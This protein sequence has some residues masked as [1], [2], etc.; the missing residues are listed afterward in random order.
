MDGR[1]GDEVSW[2][3]TRCT[4]PLAD[5]DVCPS[6]P[7]PE[8]CEMCRNLPGMPT[9]IYELMSALKD[10]SENDLKAVFGLT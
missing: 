2:Q 8:V 4:R 1:N 7:V 9:K 5:Q 3:T 10:T 6:V